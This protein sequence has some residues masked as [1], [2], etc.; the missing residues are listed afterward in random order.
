M[1]LQR[2]EGKYIKCLA[3]KFQ[4]MRRR[5]DLRQ[6][7]GNNEIWSVNND[8]AGLQTISKW[9]KTNVNRLLLSK[10][11]YSRGFRAKTNSNHSRNQK[12]KNLGFSEILD[13]L[14]LELGWFIKKIDEGLRM[15]KV[16]GVC[17]ENLVVFGD[18]PPPL[19]D[20]RR[21][22]WA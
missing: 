9:I 2:R 14:I 11:I 20:F 18:R 7:T 1:K 21:W 22:F 6:A 17:G 4:W 8:L 5:D 3:R 15:R 10:A 13:P 16:R 19:C 12:G